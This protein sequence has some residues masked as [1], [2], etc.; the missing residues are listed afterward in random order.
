MQIFLRKWL[1]SFKIGVLE[2]FAAFLIETS[3]CLRVK[4]F[5]KGT[6]L[7]CGIYK[8]KKKIEK[9]SFNS[10]ICFAGKYPGIN[11]LCKV[12]SVC[13]TWHFFFL[14]STFCLWEQGASSSL[15]KLFIIT[16]LSQILCTLKVGEEGKRKTKKILISNLINQK[17]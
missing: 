5:S 9:M 12:G 15:L 1:F 7:S 11:S 13:I 3:L 8:K 4:M 2:G 6:A 16:V 10:E 14:F 17:K